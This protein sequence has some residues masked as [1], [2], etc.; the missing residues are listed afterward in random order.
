MK[1]IRGW[2][3]Q[4][5]WTGVGIGVVIAVAGG[6]AL[7]IPAIRQGLDAGQSPTSCSPSPCFVND[8]ISLTVVKNTWTVH[9]KQQSNDYTKPPQEISTKSL[10]AVELQFTNLGSNTHSLSPSD[11]K[12]Q[13]SDQVQRG[14]VS[15]PSIVPLGDGMEPVGLA[16]HGRYGPLFLYFTNRSLQPQGSLIW[17]PPYGSAR[18]FAL[19]G[20]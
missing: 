16:S 10:M 18:V 6:V 15:D 7:A 11:F 13:D 19:P 9:V 5:I 2:V 1:A 4:G 20:T 3:W 14:P 12:F 8:E 17:S